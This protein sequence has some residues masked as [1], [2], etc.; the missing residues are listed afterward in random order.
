MAFAFAEVLAFFVGRIGA[1]VLLFG[2]VDALAFS[3]SL[4]AALGKG[5][6]NI[7]TLGSVLSSFNFRSMGRFPLASGCT[8][9]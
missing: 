1:A 5:S 8:D 2:A 6:K 9:S 3:T 4:P 7:V